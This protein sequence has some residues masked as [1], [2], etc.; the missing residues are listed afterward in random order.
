MDAGRAS[1]SVS[2]AQFG[3]CLHADTRCRE[4]LLTPSAQDGRPRLREA[5]EQRTAGGRKQGWRRRPA[6]VRRLSSDDQAQLR[7]LSHP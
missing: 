7:S 6:S 5:T 2:T 3:S 1:R 4:R